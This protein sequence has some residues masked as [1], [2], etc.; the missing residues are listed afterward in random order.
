MI[1]VNLPARFSGTIGNDSSLSFGNLAIQV[2]TERRWLLSLIEACYSCP[3]VLLESK[4]QNRFLLPHSVF[5]HFRVLGGKSD[6]RARDSL[7]RHLLREN[8]GR[9]MLHLNRNAFLQTNQPRAREGGGGKWAEVEKTGFQAW[10]HKEK[11]RARD[12]FRGLVL[13]RESLSRAR[14]RACRR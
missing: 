3:E 4:W 13:S 10:R 5:H 7:S 9:G 11:T 14:A 8:S 2:E 12:G 1:N 6:T